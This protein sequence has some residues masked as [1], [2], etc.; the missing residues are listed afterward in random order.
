MRGQFLAVWGSSRDG[1]LALLLGTMLPEIKVLI[2]WAPRGRGGAR[3]VGRRIPITNV[4]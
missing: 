1:D 2:A 4:C 3:R